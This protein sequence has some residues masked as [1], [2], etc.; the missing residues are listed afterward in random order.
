MVHLFH[1]LS[2]NWIIVDFKLNFK[3]IFGSFVINTV[4]GSSFLP[5]L[6]SFEAFIE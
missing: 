4:V 2:R 6:K 3:R 5:E 1:V